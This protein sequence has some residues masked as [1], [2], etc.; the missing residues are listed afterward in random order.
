MSEKPPFISV[1]VPTCDRQVPLIK[2]IESIRA[3]NYPE[4]EI[5]IVDQ[6]SKDGL[7]G[8]IRTL[9]NNDQKI[10]YLNSDVKCSSDSRNRGWQKAKGEII[11]FTDDDAMVGERWL[12][13]YAEAFNQ[14]D[15]NVGMVG[16]RVEPVFEI[17]RPGWLP[18]EKDYLLPSFDAGQEVKPFP[19]E[20]LPM[21]V[22]FALKRSAL[23]ESGG[24]DT[25]LG[26]KSGSKN[27]YIGGE[28]SFL[29]MRVKAAGYLILY[30]PSA[31]VY[32]P[33]P[34]RRLTRRFFLRRNFREGITTIALED[35]KAPLTS[36]RLWAD[37]K[38]HSKR[39]TFYFYLFCRDWILRKKGSSA[40]MLRAS[41]I[42]FSAGIVRQ[43]MYLKRIL[44]NKEK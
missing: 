40:Y 39:I 18:P 42:A 44:E 19:K 27:P 23:K 25:R 32:H 11:A 17:P 13:A 35:L 26:L 10:I 16:G 43:S 28:D 36:Q 24:F 38:W 29:S 5:I 4:Y 34:P 15:P 31:L 6:S 37:I 9:F 14:G 21:G 12:E 30:Q 7:A 3:N 33:V 2:C 1:V 22:N 41:E 8:Q 20:S